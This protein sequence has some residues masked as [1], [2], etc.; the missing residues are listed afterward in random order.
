MLIKGHILSGRTAIHDDKIFRERSRVPQIQD[1]DVFPLL[2][3]AGLDG[4]LDSGRQTPRAQAFDLRSVLMCLD[5]G[6]PPFPRPGSTIRLSRVNPEDFSI[7][8]GVF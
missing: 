7:P 2:I 3:L 6:L 4:R 8:D 5:F 1:A